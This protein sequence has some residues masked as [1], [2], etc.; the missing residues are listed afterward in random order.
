MSYKWLGLA[1]IIM[2]AFAANSL[3]NRLALA[4]DEIGPAGFAMIRVL[5][6]VFMLC[7]LLMIRDR[8]ALSF[9]RPNFAAVLGLS[10]YLIGFSFAYVTMDAG[11]GALI[12]F[13]TIQITMFLGAQIG[14]DRPAWTSWAGMALALL[15]LSVLSLPSESVRLELS[16]VVMMGAAAL[17]WGIYS[18]IGKGVTDP[19]AETGRNF[20]F[21]VPIVAVVLL[22]FPDAALPSLNGVFLAILSGSVTSAL[23]YALWYLLLPQLKSSTAALAQLCVPVIALIMGAL[24]LGETLTLQALASAALIMAGVSIGIFPMRVGK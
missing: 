9:G 7:V 10:T 6:G 21:S 11:I 13:G 1:A 12:L 4:T 22:L 15:G 23:G 18:L 2:I 24:F 3:L 14:G 5:S 17:G 8:G 19:L 20:L 16:A